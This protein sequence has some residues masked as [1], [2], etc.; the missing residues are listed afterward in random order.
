MQFLIMKLL[1][2]F[3]MN[4]F[5]SELWISFVI[6]VLFDFSIDFFLFFCEE[7]G[8]IMQVVILQIFFYFVNK[9]Y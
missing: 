4:K 9:F 5:A 7:K 8:E 2:S 1:N 3:N 6:V